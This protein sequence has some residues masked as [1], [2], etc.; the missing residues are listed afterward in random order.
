[1]RNWKNAKGEGHILSIDILDYEGTMIQATFFNQQAQKFNESLQEDKVYQFAN[2]T[3]KLANKRY[4]S[5]KNDYCIT[6]DQGCE[7]MEIKNDSKIKAQGFSFVDLNDI[8]D[9]TQQQSIDFIGIMMEV[10]PEVEISTKNGMRKKKELVCA[11]HTN[12]QI[13]VTVWGD[14][15]PSLELVMGNV[16]AV[17]N[18]RVSDYGGKSINCSSDSSQF[19]INPDHK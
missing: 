19:Y 15:D 7:I 12:N 2:G 9:I 1:M 13:K 14:I 5:I 16:I 10:S 17:K 11:D 4:T 18:A 6:F 8:N 3:I